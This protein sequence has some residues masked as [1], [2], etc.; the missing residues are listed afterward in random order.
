MDVIDENGGVQ[1]GLGMR[2]PQRFHQVLHGYHIL[3]ERRVKNLH[4][5]IHIC[6]RPWRGTC[7]T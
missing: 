5:A 6:D 1:Q 3:I 7:I 4:G 2:S